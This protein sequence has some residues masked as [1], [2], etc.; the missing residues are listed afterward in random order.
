MDEFQV[1]THRD[2]QSVH[3]KLIGNMNDNSSIKVTDILTGQYPGLLKIFIHTNSIDRILDLD[4]EKFKNRLRDINSQSIP[5]FF[6][7]KYGT[8]L[9]SQDINMFHVR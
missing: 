6:T 3:L 5:I 8:V 9:A 2:G 4:P 1:L 7:G